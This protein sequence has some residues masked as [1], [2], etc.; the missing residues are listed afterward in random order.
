MQTTNASVRDELVWE[1][2]SECVDYGFAGCG[3]R[4]T[5]KGALR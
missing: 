2:V 5:P 1:G 3:L 4:E